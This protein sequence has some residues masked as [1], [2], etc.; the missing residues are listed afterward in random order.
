MI[1]DT[2]FQGY[3][4]SSTGNSTLPGI[5]MLHGFLGS[6][7]DWSHYAERLEDRYA[8]FMPDL[9]GHGKTAGVYTAARFF[10]KTCDNLSQ[11]AGKIHPQPL[12]LV[13]YSMGGR[14]ALHLA[15]HYPERF[16]SAVIISSS[17]GLKT[18]E[19]KA[20]R[21]ESD[22]RLA[23]SITTD[24][25]RFLDTWYGLQL[26][27]PLKKHPL[28]P[29]ILERRAANRPEAIAAALKQLST[30]R[31]PSLWNKLTENRLPIGFFVGEKDTKYVEIGHQMVNLCPYSE[32]FIFPGCGHTLHIE[33]RHLFLER[34]QLFLQKQENREP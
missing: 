1:T 9:P 19:E 7:K 26:F 34:L 13:G 17:P 20:A 3:H 24:F 29:E 11:L 31:Q 12:H 32:L 10:E 23:E 15:L 8:C 27:E 6:G 30:G 22:D 16:R 4:V 25:N 21:R 28:F 33:N 14:L 5:L 2:S 18:P